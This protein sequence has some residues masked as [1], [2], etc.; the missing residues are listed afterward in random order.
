MRYIEIYIFTKLMFVKNIVKIHVYRH[1]LL[2]KSSQS[3]KKLYHLIGNSIPFNLTRVQGLS[4]EVS[5]FH[6]IS[7]TST[8]LLQGG[9]FENGCHFFPLALS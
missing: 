4:M 9:H 1:Q 3:T 7:N 2:Y 5:F 6:Y 8:M